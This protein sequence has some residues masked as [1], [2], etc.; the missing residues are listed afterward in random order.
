MGPRRRRGL[1]AFLGFLLGLFLGLLLASPPALLSF[2]KENLTCTSST[3]R[4]PPKSHQPP[5]V[6]TDPLKI[7]DMLDL[8]ENRHNSAKT[9]LFVGVMTAQK[10][11]PTR[12][13]AVYDTWGKELPGRIAFFSS[14]TSYPP[15]A[16]P[17]LPLVALRGVDD[18]YPP[19]KKS[20][21]MLQYMWQNYGDRF[22][23]FMRA[24]DDVYVR[25]DKLE[26]LLSLGVQD[27]GKNNVYP[28][29]YRSVDSRTWQFL[30][31]TRRKN[32]EF[33][34]IRNNVLCTGPLILKLAKILASEQT[35][36]SQAVL[37]QS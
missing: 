15:P 20:F 14:G 7:I 23:W 30:G 31:Q 35:R 19:Q 1:H 4:T 13:V 8:N 28:D 27:A 22:E 21:L 29:A 11:L 12:A 34:L 32:K 6:E 16:K 17:R 33:L 37:K 26:K 2:L 25:P 10:Y 3:G 36:K 18:S 5:P 24:D 9:L